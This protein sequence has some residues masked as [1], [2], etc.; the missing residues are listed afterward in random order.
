MIVRK[1][2]LFLVKYTSEKMPAS[3]YVYT[4]SEESAKNIVKES[5]SKYTDKHFFYEEILVNY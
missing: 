5:N 2:R 1:P 3:A 4:N